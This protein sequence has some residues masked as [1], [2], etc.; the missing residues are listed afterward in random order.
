[1]TPPTKIPIACVIAIGRQ[2]IWRLSKLVGTTAS[3]L[4]ITRMLVTW[5]TAVSSGVWKKLATHG[6][7][8]RGDGH[9][10]HAD[11][12]VQPEHAADVVVVDFA[13]LDQGGAEPGV[14]E[15]TGQSDVH[16]GL[17]GDTEVVRVR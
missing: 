8:S 6:A 7:T 10:D 9:R 3:A 14:D 1:M 13:L 5:S 4:I 11:R 15:E 16:R 2:P 17:G 12:D